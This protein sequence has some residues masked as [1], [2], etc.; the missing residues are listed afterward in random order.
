[1][2][3]RDSQNQKSRVYVNAFLCDRLLREE[4]K[5]MS[6]IRL[7]DFTSV[8]IPIGSAQPF[9]PHVEANLVIIF[10]SERAVDFVATVQ[11]TGPDGVVFSTYDFPVRIEGGASGHTLALTLILNGAAEGLTWF[12]VLLD[13]ELASKVPLLIRYTKLPT[14]SPTLIWS[15]PADASKK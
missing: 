14:G 3:T 2:A 8:D 4:D 12:N 10:R 1:M 13:G 7:I 15:K 5:T 6:A 11:G 9:V